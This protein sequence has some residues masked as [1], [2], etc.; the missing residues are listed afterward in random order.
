MYRPD[1]DQGVAEEKGIRLPDLLQGNIL[2]S[3]RDIQIG[4]E[5]TADKD[6]IQMLV[7]LRGVNAVSR[8]ARQF[9]ARPYQ[10]DRKTPNQA[11]AIITGSPLSKV[12]ANFFLG[13]N[14]PRVPIKLFSK[15]SDAKKWLK[16]LVPLPYP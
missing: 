6:Y 4:E 14:K 1:A 7:D 15:E 11:L 2:D 9:Y 3:K 13:I 10:D 5:M 16:S 8:E 12:I